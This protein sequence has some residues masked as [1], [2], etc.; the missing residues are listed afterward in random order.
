MNNKARV[1]D[2]FAATYSFRDPRFA[3]R[4]RLIQIPPRLDKLPRPKTR[5]RDELILFV[6]VVLAALREHTLLLFSSRGRFKP[7]LLAT[8][9]IGFWP[10]RFRPAILLY[11]EMYEPT[12]GFR[13]RAERRIMQL[14]DRAI[15]RYVVYTEAERQ[16]F[17]RLWRVDAAKMRVCPVYH[18]PARPGTD[19]PKKPRGRHI[20]AG[21]NSFRNYQPLIEAARQLPDYEFII[22]TTKLAGLTDLPSNVKAGAVSPQQYLQLIETAGAV[23]VPLR[24]GLHRLTGLITYFQSMW[25]KKPTIVSDAL[26]VREH[27]Q[28]GE[29]GLIVDG[30]AESY[31]QAL[32]WVLDPA[33]NEQVN[34]MCD[35]AHTSILERFT[36]EHH[37]THVLAAIDEVMGRRHVLPR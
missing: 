21:G 22:A 36:V 1:D 27:I 26:G 31:A 2:G 33:N 28:D 25:L 24:V 5:L 8:I 13:G 17:P 15:T 6:R 10:R 18:G 9:F 23:V 3:A 29:T 37:V 4:A 32:R 34:R 11:G 20:F 12:G 7:E 35:N 16:I 30:S 19:V 14:A